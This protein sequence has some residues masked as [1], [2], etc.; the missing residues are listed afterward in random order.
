M[1]TFS[2]KLL[3]FRLH[4]FTRYSWASDRARDVWQPK[5]AG[6]VDCLEQLESL[7]VAA[8][9]RE[10]ALKVVSPESLP[11]LSEKMRRH[12]LSVLTLGKMSAPQTPYAAVQVESRDGEPFNYRVAV[13]KAES[14]EKFR[15]AW[16]GGRQTEVGG[17]LGYPACCSS[18]FEQVWCREN[19]IDTTWPM[20][21]NTA[22]KTVLGE[23]MHVV[24][25]A[26][27]GNILLRW[28]GLRAV[29][30]LP[31]RFDCEA[32]IATAD[33]L[34]ALGREAGYAREMECLMETLSWPVEWSAL[35]GIAEIKTPVLK[36]AALTDATAVA[37]CLAGT[38]RLA[39]LL[40]ELADALERPDSVSQRWVRMLEAWTRTW[41]TNSAS[42]SLDSSPGSSAFSMDTESTAS[43]G[44]PGL[45]LVLRSSQR[46]PNRQQET[47][48]R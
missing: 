30:H 36:I 21:V 9:L 40:D 32:T 27:Q 38:P 48:G 7:S 47:A 11:G 12:G 39:G 18:F 44:L 37:A 19:L 5:I 8:G 43:T 3:D 29:F 26:P 10:C 42:I 15:G 33:K 6:V 24:G 28:L 25:G 20:S 41:R 17:L 22:S 35:H 13:G 46:L 4:D 16:E 1:T 34:L 23:R 14:V 2:P 45:P 31:C